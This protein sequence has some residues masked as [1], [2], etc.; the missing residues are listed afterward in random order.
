MPSQAPAV[1]PKCKH[2]PGTRIKP[3]KVE[4]E[5]DPEVVKSL[6]ARLEALKLSAK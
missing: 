6:N 3:R 4:P 1:C 5:P 2:Q